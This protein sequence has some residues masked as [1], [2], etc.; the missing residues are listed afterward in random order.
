ML[1]EDRSS[2]ERMNA[3]MQVR[4]KLTPI[5][6][7]KRPPFVSIARVGISQGYWRSQFY[8]ISACLC[9]QLA[10]GSGC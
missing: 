8:N 6:G 5:R 7:H 1:T 9:L 2:K 10:Q 4:V 3:I